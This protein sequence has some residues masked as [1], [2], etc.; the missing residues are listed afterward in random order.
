[1]V[2]DSFNYGVKDHTCPLQD[3]LFPSQSYANN[4]LSDKL[5]RNRQGGV[6]DR[7]ISTRPGLLRIGKWV[8]DIA[9][10]EILHAKIR[11][12][13]APIEVSVLHTLVEKAPG[14]VSVRELLE[15]N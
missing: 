4:P 15:I 2:F 6:M 12:R 9:A 8:F 3:L 11:R 14:I 1:M 13:L 10:R 5:P 7:S